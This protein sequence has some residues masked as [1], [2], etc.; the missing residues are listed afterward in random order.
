[1]QDSILQGIKTDISRV[2]A[3]L[4]ELGERYGKNHLQYKAVEAELR[5]LQIRMNEE[6]RN[7]KKPSKKI[8]ES[9]RRIAANDQKMV[10]E[11]EQE[12][13]KQKQRIL[14]LKQQKN[15]LDVLANEVINA[16][17]AYDAALQRSSQIH[18][19]SQVDQSNIAILNPAVPPLKPTSPKILLNLVLSIFLGTLLGTGFALLVEMLDRRVRTADDIV[20]GLGS[21][22]LSE[23]P[24]TQDNKKWF[25]LRFSKVKAA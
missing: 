7:T 12:L 14:D 13:E 23:I 24:E 16:Q 2:N 1:M 20:E 10:K 3:K 15:E 9:N 8:V 19:E 11:L 5:V 18:L 21:I 22:L 4:A 6:S 25:R 17:H